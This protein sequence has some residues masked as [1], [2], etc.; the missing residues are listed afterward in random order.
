MQVGHI[1]TIDNTEYCICDIKEYGHTKFAYT[2]S[3]P[4][5]NFNFN[6]FKLDEDEKGTFIQEVTSV[7]LIGELLKVF[8]CD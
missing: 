4:G 8:V 2:I 7:D 6:F 1:F 3:G 5:Q